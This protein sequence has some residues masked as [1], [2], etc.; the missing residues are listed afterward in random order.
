MQCEGSSIQKSLFVPH[1][2][3]SIVCCNNILYWISQK[4]QQEISMACF[5][6]V[7]YD[8]QIKSPLWPRPYDL[9]LLKWFMIDYWL[10]DLIGY[11]ISGFETD[12]NTLL[13]KTTHTPHM[14]NDHHLVI[15]LIT[16]FRCVCY[17]NI[18]S[19]LIYVARN[20][21]F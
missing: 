3:C 10:V 13:K 18:T 1:F 9:L 21:V 5:L 16:A 15:S 11:K 17:Q 6:L 7:R 12:S 19:K 4:S 20:V 14:S 8:I 2:C